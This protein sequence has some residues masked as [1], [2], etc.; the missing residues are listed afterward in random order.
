MWLVIKDLHTGVRAL[1][2]YSGSLSRESD[3]VQGTE[4]GRILAPFMYKVYINGLLNVLTNHCYSISVNRLS[5]PFPSFAN[6]V[7]LL[8][9]YP[10]FLQTFMKMCYEYSINWRYEFNHI[11]SGVVIFGECKLAHYEKMN[12]RKWLVS[13]ESVHELYEY[14]NLGVV[15]N[16]TGSFSSN[17][18]DNID[19]ERKKAGMIFS[20]NFDRRKVNPLIYVKLWWQACLPTLLYSSEPFTLTPSLLEKLERC[21][22]WFIRNIFYVP[23]VTPK[24]LLLKMSVLNSIESEISIK[25]MLFLGRLI[26]GAKTAP[27]V[28]GLFES[29]TQSYFDTNIASKGVLPS[30]WEILHKYDLFSYLESWFSDPTFPNC[31]TRKKIVKRKVHESEEKAWND[32]VYSHPNMK[33]AQTCLENVSPHKLWS[34]SEQR[35]D[36]VSR[37]H[38]QTRLMGNFGLNGDIPWLSNTD[39]AACLPCKM[40][41]ETVNHFLLDCANFREHFDSLWANLTVKIT[42]FNYI[43]GRQIS[44]FIAKLDRHQKALLLLRCLPLLFDAATVTMIIRFIAAAVGKIYKLRT[45]RLRKLEAPWLSHWSIVYLTIDFVT[46]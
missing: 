42:K 18:Q 9:L 4:H 24:Q 11:K 36:L 2:L 40:D 33:I 37:L 16:Y 39:G 30:I 32:F 21:Q 29:R 43:D 8:A 26:S 23:K 25:K 15:K 1:V 6:D 3:V 20:A 41:I 17:V 12:E 5:L 45:E 31:L 28:R 38:I 35:P 7:T 44:E 19:K 10:T 34:I 46:F 14:K 27:V 13:D 22:L